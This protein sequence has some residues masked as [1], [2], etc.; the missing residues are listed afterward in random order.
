MEF[1]A[2][3]DLLVVKSLQ[4]LNI[5]YMTGEILRGINSQGYLVYNYNNSF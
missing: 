1:D 2:S 4:A 5:N 3:G